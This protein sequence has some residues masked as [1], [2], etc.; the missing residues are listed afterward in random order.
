MRLFTQSLAGDVR[1][2]F[3]SLTTGSIADLEDFETNF[4]AKW[5]DKTNPLQLLT[6]Y[7]N[8]KWSPDETVRDFSDR[9]M[10]VYNVTQA[11]HWNFLLRKV[12]FISFQKSHF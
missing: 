4:L 3:R 5:G 9:F 10:K 8:M 12:T 2:W 1:K 6:Q 7:N 11:L